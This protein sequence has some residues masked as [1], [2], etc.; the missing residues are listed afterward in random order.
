MRQYAPSKE[1]T[2]GDTHMEM[3]QVRYF[4]ALSKTLNFTRAAEE[5]HVT[6]P[7]LT[8]S[9]KQLEDEL[10]GTLIRRER[11]HSHLT[12][13]GHRMQPMLQQCYDAAVAAKSLAKSV[14]GSDIVTMS[15]AV[16]NCVN[17]TILARCFGELLR[18]YP[19]VELKICRGT[20]LSVL[21][22]LKKG[23]VDIAI[24]GPLDPWERLDG[25]PLFREPV[26]LVVSTDHRLGRH[27]SS[28]VTVSELAG[29]VFLRRAECETKKELQTHF[30]DFDSVA[31]VEHQ[32]ET[33]HDLV[34]LI[35]AN[36]G[37]GFLS[38]TAPESS[39]IRRL[40]LADCELWLT[41]AV[42]A[43]A[44]RM[45]SAAAG[46]LLNLLRAA[47]WSPLGVNEPA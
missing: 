46:L 2:P 6:Q 36:T 24:A 38:A 22:A 3:Q 26:G 20:S 17:M 39:R 27:N 31:R 29:E 1:V 16:A 15:V 13:L 25:W 14:Q 45:R 28:E 42:F 5:C 41:V 32:V 33:D 7:A 23:E 4:L 43:V 40:K 34:A 19:G 21:E 8:R 30:P 12:E 11:S 9:I 47:D 10:G 18:A 35:E 44:G 37:V